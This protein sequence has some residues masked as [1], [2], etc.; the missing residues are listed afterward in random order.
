MLLYACINQLLVQNFAI[1]QRFKPSQPKWVT[2]LIWYARLDQGW[3]MFSPDVPTSERHLYVDAVTFGGRH[4]DPYNEAGSRVSSLPVDGYCAT[5]S[6][7]S[8]GFWF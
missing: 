4:V 7:V 2:Q 6:L 5:T 3:Q 8:A 1:P